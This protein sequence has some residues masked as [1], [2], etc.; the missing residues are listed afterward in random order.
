MSDHLEE[1]EKYTNIWE[2]ALKD[3]FLKDNEKPPAPKMS[4]DFFGLRSDEDDSDVSLNEVDTKYWNDLYQDSKNSSSFNESKG[5]KD[6][7]DDVKA[8]A[9]KAKKMANAHNPIDPNTVGK[10]QDI[11]PDLNN[12]DFK[13]LEKLKLDVEKLEISMNKK[14]GN[15]A[16][17]NT[18]SIM[19]EIKKL[20]EKIDQISDNFAGTRIGKEKN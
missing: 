11:D 19:S 4:V 8:K 1:I 17:A 18:S 20:K 3:G 2:K 12:E 16:E 5:K 10:D 15:K 13:Q 6:K 9:G 14:E 7:K